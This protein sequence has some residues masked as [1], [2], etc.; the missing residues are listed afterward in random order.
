MKAYADRMSRLGTETAFEVLAE[1]NKLRAT[2]K[3]VVSFCIGEP[4][5]DTPQYIID[6]AKQA[7]DK[8]YTH[9]G[10][11]AGLLELREVCAN[12][13]NT[14][15]TGVQYT[16]DEIVV[17]PGGKPI[18]FYTIL[19]LVNAGDE[20]IYPNPG[21]PIYE[22]MINFVGATPVPLPLLEE[23]GFVFDVQALEAA[24]SDKTKL[25][26]INSPQNPC[27]GVISHDDLAKV[28]DIANKHDLWI[29]SD[30]IYSRI[31]Y[32]GEFESITQFKG[33]KERT[34]LLDGHSKTYAMTGW[35]LGYGAMNKE[36]ADILGRLMTNSNSCTS[37]F[38]Q[39]AGKHAYLGPQDDTEHMV[40]QFKARRDLIVDGL[41]EIPGIS[42]LRPKGAFYVFPNVTDA[43]RKNGFKD[44][45]ALQE[46]LLYS[47]GVATLARTFFGSKNAGEDQEYIRLSYATSEAAIKEGLARI[48]KAL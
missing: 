48:K 29:L 38:I 43:C 6:A 18:M 46:H 9:Y 25:L 22:S 20:V 15:R 13:L 47:A 10:P 39:M 3:D 30:E 4:D 33:L 2:G 19:A 8:G 36:L 44:A 14:T 16:S 11:S 45:T 28:A 27:G 24:I 40:A 32:E 1:V 26:I 37:S 35:R 23:K 5:F 12:Y 17:T 21:F 41:N 7:L 31:L 42:C 34:I